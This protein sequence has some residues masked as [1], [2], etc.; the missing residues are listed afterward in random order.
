M[1]IQY[2]DPT[3]Y[4]A[5]YVVGDIHGC[6]SILMQELENNNFDFNHDLLICTGD[7]I[8]RGPESLQCLSLLTK[9]WF[10]TIRGNHEEMCI[11]S[12]YDFNMR[13]LH[14]NNGG[15]WFFVLKPQ[16]K[17]EI[18]DQLKK[19]PIAIEINF[20]SKRIGIVH[21]DIDIN[22]WDIFKIKIQEGDFKVRGLKSTYHN[23]L[24]GRGRIKHLS[25]HYEAV[26]NVDTIYL[27]HT[28][29]KEPVQLDN[30]HYIDIGSYYSKK[31]CV[32]KISD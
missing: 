12:F 19:L 8:D 31:L 21:A 29:V 20:P 23:A 26:K 14:Q 10:K 25:D 16:R 9:T 18:I 7:L 6:Y 24:W 3:Q 22:D 13:M 2:I 17:L 28:I 15:E 4:K 27:G 5:I 1:T 11:Q 30:C 32:L